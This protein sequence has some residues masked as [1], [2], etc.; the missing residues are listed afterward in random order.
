MVNTILWLLMT[1]NDAKHTAE[2]PIVL[3]PALRQ[4]RHNNSDGFVCGYDCDITESIVLELQQRI[5]DLE[6]EKVHD[7]ECVKSLERYAGKLN[8]QITDLERQLAEAQGREKG[9]VYYFQQLCDAV[10]IISKPTAD[11]YR[12]KITD[13]VEQR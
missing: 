1:P 4:Y 11:W 10:E 5:T 8:T 9:L 3:A 2:L 13:F 7:R 6:A 12:L